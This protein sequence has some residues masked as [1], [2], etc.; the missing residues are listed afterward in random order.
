MFVRVCVTRL[1]AIKTN[2]ITTEV[3]PIL[4]QTG[5]KWNLLRGLNS[6]GAQLA[7]PGVTVLHL[8]VIPQVTKWQTEAW[9]SRHLTCVCF[10]W[11]HVNASYIIIN[12]ISTS[13]QIQS[14]FI[15]LSFLDISDGGQPAESRVDLFDEQLSW[16]PVKPLHRNVPFFVLI[17]ALLEITNNNSCVWNTLPCAAKIQTTGTKC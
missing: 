13:E 8:P 7:P 11:R 9:P 14:V 1:Q 12:N 2:Q 6:R 4:K 10:L 3:S 5:Y 16:L 17:V 15:T